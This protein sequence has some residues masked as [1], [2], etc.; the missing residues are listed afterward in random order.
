[1]N[2]PLEF[3]SS[4]NMQYQRQKWAVSAVFAL[5]VVCVA[6]ESNFADTDVQPTSGTWATDQCVQLAAF[7][8]TTSDN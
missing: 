5:G 4:A 6:G 8:S 7:A 1:M 3:L 2:T